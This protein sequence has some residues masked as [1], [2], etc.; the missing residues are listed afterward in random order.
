MNR[1]HEQAIFQLRFL[2]CVLS[3]VTGKI[4]YKIAGSQTTFVRIDHT[5]VR[6][7]VTVQELR[8]ILKLLYCI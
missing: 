1:Q 6:T 7:I 3:S 2:Y 4:K 5:N 8:M